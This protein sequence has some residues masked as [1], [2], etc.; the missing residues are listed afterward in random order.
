MFLFVLSY[1]RVTS[2]AECMRTRKRYNG[3]CWIILI[4]NKANIHDFFNISIEVVVY[5]S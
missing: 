2:L 4:A 5:V 1:Q 3:V